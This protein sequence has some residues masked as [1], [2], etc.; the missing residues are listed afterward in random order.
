MFDFSKVRFE[1]A[2]VAVPEFAALLSGHSANGH[3]PEVVVRELTADE[4]RDVIR[5]TIQKGEYIYYDTALVVYYG[6]VTGELE[7]PGKG[8]PL[9]RS[10]QQVRDLPGPFDR[11]L[12]RLAN[13]ILTLSALAEREAGTGENTELELEKKG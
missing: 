12:L 11:P 6:A 4:K 13:E 8:E 10:V 5:S 7:A 9:F 1:R 2:A 3:E